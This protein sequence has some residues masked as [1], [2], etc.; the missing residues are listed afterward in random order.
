MGG[1]R[2]EREVSHACG[3]GVG[4][5]EGSLC[6]SHFFS[7]PN[8][9]MA[10]GND[11]SAVMG[12]ENERRKEK[13]K[14]SDVACI[15]LRVG[16]RKRKLPSSLSCPRRREKRR[17]GT[18]SHSR[19]I[20]PPPSPHSPTPVRS[21]DVTKKKS[22]ACLSVT[23][24]FFSFPQKRRKIPPSPPLSR[25][26]HLQQRRCVSCLSAGK[27]ERAVAYRSRTRAVREL[28]FD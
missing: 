28:R 2:A 26:A 5:G 17:R 13:K 18:A 9:N 14:S 21:Q 25:R 7:L 10:K 11:R 16:Q 1:R 27:V 19:H 8:P 23:L 15:V 4:S 12:E 24:R 20:L 6:A 3:V 22:K